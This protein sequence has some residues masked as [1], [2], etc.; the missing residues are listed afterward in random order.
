MKAPFPKNEVQRLKVL[1]HY[2]ILDTPREEV[3]DDL[4]N[5]AALI[6]GAPIALISLVDEH[7]QWFKAKVGMT[8]KETGRDVSFCAHAIGQEDLFIVPDAT[9]DKRFKDNPLVTAT[10]KIR[11]YAGSPLVTREGHSLG[12]L[13]VIDKVPRTLTADQKKALGILARLVMTQLELRSTAR[14][15]AQTRA[16]SAEQNSEIKSAK[17]GLS[18]VRRELERLAKARALK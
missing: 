8:V 17:A 15:L 3:F 12:T 16:D 18:H 5:L 13:C 4:A 7:R 14:E 10:P 2:D 11:F 1:W 6:C 9:R